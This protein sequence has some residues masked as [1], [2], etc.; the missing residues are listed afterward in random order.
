MARSC[1]INDRSRSSDLWRLLTNRSTL[2]TRNSRWQ[3]PPFPSMT[4]LPILRVKVLIDMPIPPC[5]TP[6]WTILTDRSGLILRVTLSARLNPESVS[7]ER[8]CR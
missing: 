1:L 8:P 2:L 3:L 6:L 5:P 7:M 4:H